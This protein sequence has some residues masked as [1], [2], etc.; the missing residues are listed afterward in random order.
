MKEDK[1]GQPEIACIYRSTRDELAA[2]V[3]HADITAIGLPSKIDHW[4][5]PSSLRR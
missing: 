3:P 4:A 2:L 1:P 5:M